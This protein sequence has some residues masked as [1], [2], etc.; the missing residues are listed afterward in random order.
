MKRWGVF[1]LCLLF[2]G[3]FWMLRM[4]SQTYAD[5]VSVS[6]IP[7]SNIDG[8]AD[9][10]SSAVTISA[11]CSASG[12]SL[13]SIAS[14]RNASRFHIDSKDLKHISGD[15]YEISAADLSKYVEHILGKDVNLDSFLDDSYVF[16]FAE[17]GHKRVPVLVD[18]IISFSPQYMALGSMTVEPDSVTVYGSPS[19]LRNISGVYTRQIMKTGVKTDQHGLVKLRQPDGI[20]L[21]EESVTYSLGVTRFVEIP[22]SVYV[23]TDNVPPGVELM[24]FPNIAEVTCRCV[25]PLRD[26]NPEDISIS[27]DYN[28]FTQSISGRCIS[29]CGNIPEGVVSFSVSP[30]VFDCIEK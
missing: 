12:Y 21:S 3:M 16:R 5:L 29:R 2:S 13:L 1:L 10:A 6:V 26:C 7:E 19:V 24:V 17:E 14:R 22:V 28:D 9:L 11:R 25:F 30:E 4:L 23:G 27:I 18:D 20:R 8:R 15:S